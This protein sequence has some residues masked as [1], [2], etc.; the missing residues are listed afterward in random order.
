MR[1]SLT[2]IGGISGIIKCA[3]MRQCLVFYWK[4]VQLRIKEPPDTSNGS[5][6]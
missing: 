4:S 2:D 5:F 1:L 6:I 3:E